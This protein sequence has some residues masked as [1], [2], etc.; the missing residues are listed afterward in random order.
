MGTDLRLKGALELL[1][2]WS[3][4]ERVY[5]SKFE[6]VGWKRFCELYA[7]IDRSP[8]V[9]GD[10]MPSSL[11]RS[12]NYARA[13]NYHVEDIERARSGLTA[14]FWDQ[15]P[16]FHPCGWF[17]LE[18]Q[19]LDS[20]MAGQRVVLPYGGLS[21]VAT[22]PAIMSP[23]G[24]ASDMSVTIAVLPYERYWRECEVPFRPQEK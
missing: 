10:S 2:G 8:H 21:T 6:V 19:V 9:I 11:E 1:L 23:R 15:V 17:M 24:L 20:S 7:Y 4:E 22:P 3:S 12:I 18:C 16:K 13:C 5:E 14:A